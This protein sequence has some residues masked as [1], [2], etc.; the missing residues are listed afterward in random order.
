[1]TLDTPFFIGLWAWM[2]AHP[3]APF[4]DFI[5]AV[6]RISRLVARERE[7]KAS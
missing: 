4:D 6:A 1:M 5:D 7:Q 3:D 2:R